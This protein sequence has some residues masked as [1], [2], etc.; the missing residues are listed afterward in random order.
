MLLTIGFKGW[1]RGADVKLRDNDCQYFKTSG[2]P[3]RTKPEVVEAAH[4]A[5]NDGVAFLERG[6]CKISMVAI[7]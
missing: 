7:F 6:S 5:P 3:F 2:G 1:L 4:C